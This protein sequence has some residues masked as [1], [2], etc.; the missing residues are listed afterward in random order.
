[1]TYE[2]FAFWLQGYLE[3]SKESGAEQAQKILEKLKTMQPAS[4]WL[5]PP[6]IQP[7]PGWEP[8]PPTIYP[9][10]TYQTSGTTT[11]LRSQPPALFG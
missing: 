9:V 6:T 5:S 1:M 2:Q 3:G 10:V 8:L 7:L 4:P 11:I